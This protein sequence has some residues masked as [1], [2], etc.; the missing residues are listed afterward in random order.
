MVTKGASKHMLIPGGSRN[1]SQLTT[2]DQINENRLL[3][4]GN[5][6]FVHCITV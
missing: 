2:C 3:T 1:V 5:R 6:T 4:G